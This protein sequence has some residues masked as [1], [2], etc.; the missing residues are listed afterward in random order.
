MGK[1]DKKSRRGKITAGSY[2][3]RRKRKSGSVKN[4]PVNVL[5]ADDSKS[6]KVKVRQ[7]VG[8]PANES[9]NANV[10]NDPLPKATKD[11]KTEG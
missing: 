8:Y 3:K 4:I 5:D 6:S 1:G 2:G 7:D 9:E 11:K 10:E